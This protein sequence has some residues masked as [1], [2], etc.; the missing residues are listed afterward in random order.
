[1][2]L[3]LLVKRVEREREREKY[4]SFHSND[5]CEMEKHKLVELNWN[6]CK[7]KGK[8]PET[9]YI[10]SL[11]KPTECECTGKRCWAYIYVC[12]VLFVMRWVPV[13][14][15]YYGILFNRMNH[16]TGI[17]CIYF[18]VLSRIL[19]YTRKKVAKN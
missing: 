13:R 3:W 2:F 4:V 14:W 19:L 17:V 12:I 7:A 5:G 10:I 18:S 15:C 11:S 1:M 6:E 16:I 8:N 9:Q